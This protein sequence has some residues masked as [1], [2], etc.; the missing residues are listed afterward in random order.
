MTN[1]DLLFNRIDAGREG[2]NIGLKTG[3]DKLDEYT[4]GVQK[5][6]YTLVFGLS[7][8]GKTALV[9]YMI[10]RTLKDNPEKDIKYIYFSLELSAD[11]LL[12]KLMCLYIYEEFGKV[13]SYTDLMSWQ[14]ILSD[15]NYEYV[16][17]SRAWLNTISEK[18]LIYDK[19]LNAK[20]FYR[21]LMDLLSKWG[22]FTK[23]SDGRRKIYTKTNPEQYVIAVVDHIGLCMPDGGVTKKQEIDLISQYAVTLREKCQVSFF[24]LQQENRNSANMDRRK[25]DMTESSAEDL[26]DTGS[27]YNDCEICIGV[28]Y[29]LKHKVKNHRGYPIIVEDSD[30]DAFKGLRDRYRSCVLIKNRLGISDRLIPVNFFGEI[31][32]FTQLPKPD[33][34]VDWTPYLSLTPEAIEYK[35]V[36]EEPSSES[37]TSVKFSF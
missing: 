32:Y 3:I 30:P 23:S 31:G 26:K 13:I 9:L 27:T 11:L 19:A 20:T 34:V 24:I 15:E 22:T 16:K 10:Y 1:V 6:I 7:G 2:K 5:G 14:G 8:S 18:L 25:M 28:Y 12:A 4:G 36:S 21:T 35:D 17:L 37:S 33:T 29:P